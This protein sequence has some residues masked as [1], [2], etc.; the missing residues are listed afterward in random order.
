M[1]QALF[2]LGASERACC[3]WQA[4]VPVDT[5]IHWYRGSRRSPAKFAV[6]TKTVGCREDAGSVVLRSELSQAQVD[7]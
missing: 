7:R 1:E 5:G 2:F 6:V 3:M 4:Q